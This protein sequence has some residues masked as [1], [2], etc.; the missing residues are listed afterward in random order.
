MSPVRPAAP[1]HLFSR[2]WIDETIELDAPEAEV[3]ALVEDVA[4]WDTWTPGLREI[5]FR[6]D[7]PIKPR[8]RFT[9]I[10]AMKPFPALWLPC[11]LFKSEPGYIEWGGG[12]LG[13]VIRHRFEL[14]PLGD[15]R[16]AL[17]HVEY[18]TNFLA[19][20]LLPFEKVAYNHDHGWSAAIRERFAAKS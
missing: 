7:G 1:K 6:G 5:R 2:V 16:T 4:G 15:G 17:R 10:L 18:A 3:Q 9:M 20:I 8:G 12:G 19:L 13:S 11:V 14:T